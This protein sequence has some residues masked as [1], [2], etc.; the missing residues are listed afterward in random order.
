MKSSLL[1][2]LERAGE[3]LFT[4][5]GNVTFDAL[6]EGVPTRV[7]YRSRVEGE[8]NKFPSGDDE[9]EGT[10]TLHANGIVLASYTGSLKRN[11]AVSYTSHETS[12]LV[13]G[14]KK[15][16]G[17]ETITGFDRPIIMKT[18]MDLSPPN[19]G[20]FTNTGYERR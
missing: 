7:T 19:K 10:I 18:E 4:E 20:K 16:Q 5:R 12:K 3:K 1:M 8:D 2:G 13:D 17:E 15:V 14:G 9:G 6:Q 11:G